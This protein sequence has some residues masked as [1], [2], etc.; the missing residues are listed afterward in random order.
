MGKEKLK[1]VIWLAGSMASGKTTLCK[2]LLEKLT[3]GEEPIS[4]ID[5]GIYYT[6]YK[7]SK[8]IALGKIGRNQCTGLDSVYS[9]LGSDGV[10]TTMKA[11]LE[12]K[13]KYIIVD[14]AFATHSWTRKWTNEGLREKMRLVVI[15]QY[16]DYW[17]NL[18]RLAQRKMKKHN[19]NP[20][21][22][23]K[24][25]HFGD[26]PNPDT[27]YKN[28]LSKNSESRNIFAKFE[29]TSER[30]EDYQKANATIKM[31]V[32]DMSAKKVLKT[33]LKFI[34]ENC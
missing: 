10:T 31:E 27:V 17:N 13:A 14:C 20:K 8:V 33:S 4:V 28:V 32:A 21:S 34:K 24:Y 23:F 7:K 19:E 18:K 15:F 2:G 3:D 16:L 5:E 9:K 22:E 6:H 12:T 25:E 29:G 1:N 30:Q 11:A 26:V